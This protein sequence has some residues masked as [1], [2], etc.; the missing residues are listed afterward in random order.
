MSIPQISDTGRT[1]AERLGAGGASR[2]VN[3]RPAD[4]VPANS[5]SINA[6]NLDVPHQSSPI[7]SPAKPVSSNNVPPPSA[8]SQ[9]KSISPRV[10]AKPTPWSM[11]AGLGL[12]IADN[13]PNFFSPFA[14]FAK[15]ARILTRATAYL[16]I[17]LFITC[18]VYLMVPG[19]VSA[20]P[21]NSVLGW[22]YLSA[23]FAASSISACV[24]L[25]VLKGLGN[26]SSVVGAAAHRRFQNR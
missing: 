12:M 5:K 9:T 25:A 23:M 10:R 3:L 14:F 4:F 26:L 21:I 18:A 7:N 20:F 19:M 11:V 22:V 16:S 1:A 15:N 13:V 17:P 2:V 24:L 6:G 8:P